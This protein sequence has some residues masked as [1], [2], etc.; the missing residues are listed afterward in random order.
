MNPAM[1]IQALF[2]RHLS[3][4]AL[5]ALGS[6]ASSGAKLERPLPF[7]VALMPVSMDPNSNL[8]ATTPASVKEGE[9]Q[10]V[11]VEEDVTNSI[12]SA[13]KG[14]GFTDVYSLSYPE[15]SSVFDTK[16]DKEKFEYWMSAAESS[17]ADILLK[18]K[19]AYEP[20]IEGGINEKFWLNLP[21]F[22]LG[23]PFCYFINDRT[24]EAT[25]RMV[26]EFYNVHAPPKGNAGEVLTI[27]I[28]V[29]YTGSQ[30]DF[31]DRAGKN[32]GAY[33][34]SL[35]VPAGLLVR[36]NDRIA[37]A[38]RHAAL[39]ELSQA[40]VERVATQKGEFEMNY[41]LARFSLD[42]DTATARRRP[43][44]SVTLTATVMPASQSKLTLYNVR[45]ANADL[46]GDDLSDRIGPVLPIEGTFAVPADAD[47]I[48]LEIE[49]ATQKKRSYT[50]RIE[51][52]R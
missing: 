20:N 52:A 46:G 43:D 50:I 27:P 15:D 9:P 47:L 31:T 25:A 38:V 36:N 29:D 18:V 35:L 4:L 37:T 8:R 44:G 2:V 7:R 12:V 22:L 49:D 34:L 5:F 30:L 1:R 26:A 21:L 10:L 17:G 19:V 23:G 42:L 11:L 48:Q 16:P 32:A 6:C 3:A 24:Y 39:D 33:A 51:Q 13:L 40:L 41:G 45:C 28:V 14:E